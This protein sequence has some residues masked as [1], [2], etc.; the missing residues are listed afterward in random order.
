MRPVEIDF[1]KARDVARLLSLV[2][3]DRRYFQELLAAIPVPLAIIGAD[4][5][6]SS[7]NDAFQKLFDDSVT[8]SRTLVSQWL[9]IAEIRD[10]IRGVIASGNPAGHELESGGNFFALSFQPIR[11]WDE[12]VVFL[13]VRTLE[14]PV[15]VPPPGPVAEAAPVPEPPA[16][17]WAAST[18]IADAET[19]DIVSIDTG[20]L[21]VIAGKWSAGGNLLGR[22]ISPAD[23]DAV[24][25]F[26][27]GIATGEP[28]I[29]CDYSA[30]SVAG[31]AIALRDIARLHEGR[32]HGITIDNTVARAMS[33]QRAQEHRIA[34]LTRMASRMVHDSNNLIMIMSGYGEDLLHALPPE[35]SLRVNVG[36]ILAA[37][38]RLA[39]ATRGLSQFTKRAPVNLKPVT[40]DHFLDEVRLLERVL[41][42]GVTLTVVPNAPGSVAMA[43]PAQ[44]LQAV[45]TLIQRAASGL[46]NGG[47]IVVET[48]TRIASHIDASS[49]APPRRACIEVRDTGLAIH[50]GVLSRL[51]E[52]DSSS[53]PLRQKLPAAYQSVRDMGGDVEA[54]PSFPT[55]TSFRILLASSII[56]KPAPIPAEVTNTPLEAAPKPK[57]RVKEVPEIDTPSQLRVSE[58]LP[59]LS[60]TPPVAPVGPP[61]IPPEFLKPAEPPKAPVLEPLPSHEKTTVLVV[62][63]EAGIRSL[64]RKVLLREGYNVLEATQGREGLDTAKSYKGKIDLLLTDVLMPEMNGI[65]L[66]QSLHALR[67]S[68]RILLIS[69]YMGSNALEAEKLPAGTAFLHKPFTLNALLGK[70]K[71]VLGVTSRPAVS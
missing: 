66:A 45:E 39:A 32:I 6:V 71:E 60:G 68:T 4:M 20:T 53:D 3:A 35:S 18:W 57:I 25:G 63:D 9:D 10:K 58:P 70:V 12:D 56:P 1:W 61:V 44:L 27:S 19:L 37:G 42:H 52:P 8:G 41:P 30:L 38:E 54:S 55:G 64:L 69:G 24:R 2:E 62:D 59:I 14:R 40:I 16:P 28:L 31:T 43:D 49:P 11:H 46:P 13:S 17:A 65:E 23:L 7:C 67:P 29:S 5:A 36:E 21:P 33:E 26:F 50:P 48:S 15:A 51:F 47:N 22:N 34:A